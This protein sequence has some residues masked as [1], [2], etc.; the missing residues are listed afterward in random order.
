MLGG[1]SCSSSRVGAERQTDGQIIMPVLTKEQAFE[2]VME[3]PE[4][5]RAEVV[6][7]LS[8]EDVSAR[9][10]PEQEA[11]LRESRRQHRENPGAARSW[12]EIEAGLLAK[13]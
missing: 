8:G 9:L 13:I 5:E 7:R 4:P 3:L 12:D 11:E 1:K 10:T 6:A 2:A